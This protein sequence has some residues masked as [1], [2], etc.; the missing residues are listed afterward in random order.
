MLPELVTVP[1]PPSRK[2]PNELA[3]I[4]PVEVFVTLPPPSISTPAA[5]VAVMTLELVRDPAQDQRRPS[6]ARRRPVGKQLYF[7]DGA[8]ELVRVPAPPLKK[9]PATLPEMD[10][11]AAFVTLPPA[12]SATP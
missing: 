10:A 1:E 9:T 2:T 7:R 8:L 4:V 11:P 12:S 6:G 3:E 5:P